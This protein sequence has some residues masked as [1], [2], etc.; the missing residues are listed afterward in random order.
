VCAC[1]FWENGWGCGVFLSNSRAE[2]YPASNKWRQG[3]ETY[4]IKGSSRR[5]WL[6]LNRLMHAAI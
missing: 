6:F 5:S 1:V 2:L 3:G 4:Q